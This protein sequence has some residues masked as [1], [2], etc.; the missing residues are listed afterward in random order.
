[1]TH[2]LFLLDSEK[3]CANK[4]LTLTRN[5]AG[6]VLKYFLEAHWWRGC[7]PLSPGVMHDKKGNNESNDISR[8]GLQILFLFP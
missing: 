2:L 7:V 3:P 1:L 8:K 4:G 5:R 6:I